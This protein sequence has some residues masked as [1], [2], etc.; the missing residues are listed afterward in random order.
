M[1]SIKMFALALTL[2]GGVGLIYGGFTYTSDSQQAGNGP[3]KLTVRD[4]Q[5]VN[6]PVRAGVVD[7]GVA[8]NISTL[9]VKDE[10]C[11]H[12]QSAGFDSWRQQ[13]GSEDIQH[14]AIDSAFGNPRRFPHSMS[15]YSC[16]P[17]YRP[18]PSNPLVLHLW[19][20]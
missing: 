20:F 11:I 19:S 14:R 1:N 15:V 12:L 5:T 3:L 16:A 7:E 10:L 2:A 9:T 4:K 18:Y 17:P 8:Q 13:G 6:I